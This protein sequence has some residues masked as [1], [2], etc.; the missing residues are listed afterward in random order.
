[1][2][3]LWI[4]CI[5]IISCVQ[6]NKGAENSTQELMIFPT[7]PPG[8]VFIRAGTKLNIT[9]SLNSNNGSSI[10]D[11][12]LIWI[13]PSTFISVF[14]SVTIRPNI[15]YVMAT[16]IINRTME[17]DSGVYIC[18]GFRDNRTDGTFLQTNVTVKI[19]PVRGSCSLTFYQCGTKECIP[20]RYV[21][22][23]KMDCEDGSD[24]ARTVCGDD[25]CSGKVYCSD[26]RCY[27][28]YCC[29]QSLE[30]D[31]QSDITSRCCR[32]S[33]SLALWPSVEIID[34][35]K[36]YDSDMGFLQSTVYTI[37]GCA[38]S[39]IVVVTI[40]VVAVCRVHMNQNAMTPPN[41]IPRA[42]L[43]ISR[44][45]YWSRRMNMDGPGLSPPSTSLL[46]TYNI[47]NGV[48]LVGRF[49][50]PPPYSEVADPPPIYGPPPPYASSD[51]LFQQPESQLPSVNHFQTNAENTV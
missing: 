51:N 2:K 18:R 27:D 48:Q 22:D 1:M 24:E 19:M 50:D 26:G 30:V 44:T 49:T 17:S 21:C 5:Y 20:P 31:C 40:M 39:F 6:L 36:K 43:P 25:P 9:C 32:I 16:L 42:V 41:T 4:V 23:G 12:K 11:F 14:R 38:V 15:N 7:N 29:D 45:P 3:W 35:Q 37:I 46:V 47:N 13:A 8:Y 28:D 34:H 10:K 33:H